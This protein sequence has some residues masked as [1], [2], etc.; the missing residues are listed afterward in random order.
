MNYF[1][2]TIRNNK[3]IIG[4]LKL[5]LNIKIK[6]DIQKFKILLFLLKINFSKTKEKTA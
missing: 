3:V 1:T 4:T 5:K 2:V 6:E